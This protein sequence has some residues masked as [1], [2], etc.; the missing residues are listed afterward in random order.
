MK[1]AMILMLVAAA[2]VTVHP[3]SYAGEATQT[4]R[5]M[6]D[7][8]MSIQT[9]QNKQ[10]EE[11]RQVRRDEIK[12][13]ILRNF[14]VDSMA[15]QTLGAQWETIGGSK[16][17]E[18]K[19]VFQDLFLDSYTRLVLDF[20]RRE[21][22]DYAKEDNPGQGRI[23]VKTVI[24]RANEAIPVDYSLNQVGKKLLV[25]D[26]RIDGVSIVDNYQKSFARVIKQESYEG[27]IKKMRLQQRAAKSK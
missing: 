5:T 2:M 22:I 9:D 16:Q 8:V 12:K 20:L 13:V 6:L 19:E 25:K 23:I 17:A 10:G 27:L 1:F 3:P 24:V 11:F 7:E 18:F 26:V 4:V 14:D 21:K 15:K